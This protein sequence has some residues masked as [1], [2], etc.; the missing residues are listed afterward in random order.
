MST[1]SS[2]KAA[3]PYK[4]VNPIK[5]DFCDKNGLGV[6]ALALMNSYRNKAVTATIPY[7]ACYCDD[8][9]Q[10]IQAMGGCTHE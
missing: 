7:K 2:P 9:R 5:D 6:C 8:N 1:K 4:L 3:L 10:A